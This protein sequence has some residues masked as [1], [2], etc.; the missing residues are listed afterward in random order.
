MIA[1]ARIAA[2]AAL[3][4]V[5]AGQSDLPRALA[6]ERDVLADERDRALAGEI[7]TGTLR[8]QAEC[9]H[10]IVHA[11]GRSLSRL[12]PE[13][14]DILRLSIFQLRH[15]DR[16]PASAIVNDAVSLARRAG[17]RS[18]AP[19]VNAVLRTI[20]RQSHRL[21]LPPDPGADGDR[22]GQLAF[23]SVTLSH[24]AWLAER[25]LDRYGFAAA[26]E[27]ARFDNAPAPLTLRVNRLLASAE[28]V[29]REL[30]GHGVEVRPGRY[31]PDALV[32]DQGNPLATPLVAD[33][34][35][36]IQDEASQLVALAVAAQPGERIL[37]ACASPGGKTTAMAADMGGSGLV[38]AADVRA[39]RI[40]LL[41]R[42][43]RRAGA[44]SVRIVQADVEGPLPFGERFDAVLLDVPCSGLGTLR[45]DPDLKWRRRE[46]ELPALAASQGRM[47]DRAFAA[48]RPGG[49]LVYA[50]CSSEPEENEAVVR[51]W[52]AG[53]T[54]ARPGPPRAWPARLAGLLD[55]DGFLRTQPPRD[56]LEGFFAATLE[57][58][59]GSR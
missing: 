53:R 9:D 36:L 16:V 55:G 50:T 37:D 57:K 35:V 8:W 28:E 17:K 48:V 20:S 54:D 23:L 51:G 46:D 59:G 29:V 39:A 21:P 10:L 2:Y 34:R 56:G 15:L 22:E 58:T 5:T 24:P 6:R 3:R 33:G 14:R 45:R 1:P 31:A 47:L 43:V 4:S 25:W 27:W 44:A 26:V 11:S 52:L 30:S 41:E 19:L 42:T 38:V 49:R 7:V 40:A 12:D 32:V 18:A 13:V